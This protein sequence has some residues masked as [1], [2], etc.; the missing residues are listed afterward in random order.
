MVVEKTQKKILVDFL[1][2]NNE[3]ADLI[4]M[5]EY[6]KGTH[7]WY[8]MALSHVQ[9]F[10]QY[11]YQTDD[12]EFSALNYEFIKDYDLYLKTVRKCSKQ[13]IFKVYK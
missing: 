13:Y 3:I 4:I 8:V 9:E 10:I 1:E 6:A 5:K 12:L 2:H 7:K 11:K